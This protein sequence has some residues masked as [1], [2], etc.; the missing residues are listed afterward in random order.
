MAITT[1]ISATTAAVTPGAD[2]EF[3]TSGPFTLYADDLAWGEHVTLWRLG[4][5]GYREATNKHGT[6]TVSAAP[7]MVYIDAPGTYRL[8]KPETK[9]PA[10]I[11]YEEA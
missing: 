6:I 7:N 3:T 9:Q 10:A 1:K 8:S 11:G 5:T 4:P 2:N